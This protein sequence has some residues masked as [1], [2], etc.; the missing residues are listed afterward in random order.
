MAI[1]AG[2]LDRPIRLLVRDASNAVDELGAANADEGWAL[3]AEVFAELIPMAAS[4]RTGLLQ[5]H[6][7]VQVQRYR[8]RWMPGLTTDMALED[9]SRRY[10]IVDF[11]QLKREAEVVITGVVHQPSVGNPT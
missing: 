7:A 2:K 6:S 9:D 4:E 8:I 3:F 10:E 1:E 11:S 5:A